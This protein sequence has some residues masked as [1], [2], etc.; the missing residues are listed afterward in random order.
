[1]TRVILDT[2]ILVSAGITADGD[3]A[4]ILQAALRGEFRIRVCP[5]VVAEYL[6]VLNRSKFTRYGF[7][8][9]W[10][11][12][13]LVL[14]DQLPVDPEDLPEGPDPDDRVFLALAQAGGILVTGNL[15]H[16]P[17]PL[18]GNAEVMSPGAFLGR[19]ERGI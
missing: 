7:P 12:R 14:A 9:P 15:K 18:R 8:P 17:E 11:R 2:N 6:D 10:V 1:M 19:L 4:R 16:F 5:S 13:L 3:C